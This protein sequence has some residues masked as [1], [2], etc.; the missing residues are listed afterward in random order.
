MVGHATDL[1]LDGHG[2]LLL[3]PTLRE[4]AP[5]TAGDA[6]RAGQPLR[7]VGRAALERTSR[8]VAA[9]RNRRVAAGGARQLSLL[10]GAPNGV[11]VR[12]RDGGVHAR[13]S[14]TKCWTGSRS[15]PTALRG[16]DV[17][18]RRSCRGDPRRLGRRGRLV[19]IDRDPEAVRPR[20]VRFGDGSALR[21]HP[22]GLRRLAELRRRPGV[23]GVDGIAARSRRLLA[24]ARRSR[25]RLQ[26][27]CTTVRS[28]CAW[29]RD[30]GRLAAEWLAR[31]TE[32]EIADVHRGLAKNGL[33]RRIARAIVRARARAPIDTH[34]RA[35]RRRGRRRSDARAAAS[36][37]R[38]ARSRPFGST[39]TT[40]SRSS[41]RALPQARRA[42]APRRPARA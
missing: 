19:A 33:R 28:T 40:S 21:Y 10:I 17:R 1:D 3:P 13:Y 18:S 34:R 14:W 25:A 35:R 37:R 29:I 23:D 42:L 5:S 12:S 22:D 11:P 41:R 20:R 32:R 6:D 30:S 8:A 16:R 39:S 27:S 26:L 36:I 38:R 24:A 31:A 4:F 7:A 2:R 15:A 9:A